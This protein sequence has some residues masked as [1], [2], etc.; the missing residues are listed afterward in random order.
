MSFLKTNI[1]KI[2]EELKEHNI[3][4]QWLTH[5]LMFL[6]KASTPAK[7]PPSSKKHAIFLLGFSSQATTISPDVATSKMP[8]PPPVPMTLAMS[9][10]KLPRK[11]HLAKF[12]LINKASYSKAGTEKITNNH[13][14]VRFIESIEFSSDTSMGRNQQVRRIRWFLRHHR[15]PVPQ[16]VKPAH[17][18][19]SAKQQ[20]SIQLR[21]SQVNRSAEHIN[22]SAEH[23]NRSQQLKD[24][25]I[26]RKQ[27]QAQDQPKSKSAG[28]PN[29]AGKYS[30]LI[31]I[32]KMSQVIEQ[33]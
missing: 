22:R 19:K 30:E 29:A 27:I 12:T 32:Q 18:E 24:L 6:Q 15:L 1:E 4:E 26:A 31:A 8:V 11:L 33:D 3:K 9:P 20:I 23:I 25:Q 17:V 21:P 14:S 28:L 5:S 2:R 13:K 10:L 7:E 16:A